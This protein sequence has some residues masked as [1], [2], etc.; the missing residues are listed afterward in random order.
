MKITNLRLKILIENHRIIVF[1]LIII[2]VYW[3]IETTVDFLIFYEEGTFIEHLFFINNHEIW[4]RTVVVTSLLSLSF[5]AQ[6]LFSK[7]RKA[8]DA[9]REVQKARQEKLTM[10]GQLAGGVGHEIRNPLGAIKNATYFLNMVL[11][12]PIPEVKET[13]EVLEKEVIISENIINSLLGFARPKVPLLQKVDINKLTQEILSQIKTPENIQVI[14]ELDD[15]LPMILADPEQLSHV[16][17]NIIINAFQAMNMGGSFFIKSEVQSSGWI[18]ISFSDSGIGIAEENLKNIFE[19]LFTTKAKGIGL[20]LAIA[21]LMTEAQGGL[22]E[23]ESKV[24]KG[25]TFT[26]R[27]PIIIKK[28]R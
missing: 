9:Y 21:K 26:V 25:T 16:F 19:P 3:I 11:E 28:K 27:L 13:L 23:V 1:S 6:N 14:K 8:E 12:D 22:I 20:G 5:Y 15:S 7:R 10:L 2:A 4:M 18:D 17:R 24:S